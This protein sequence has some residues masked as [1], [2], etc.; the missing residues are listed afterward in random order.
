MKKLFKRLFTRTYTLTYL[1][2]N[3][4]YVQKFKTYEAAVNTALTL[5]YDDQYDPPDVSTN[6]AINGKP[7]DFVKWDEEPFKSYKRNPK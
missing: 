5:F 7:V 2:N 6:I 4:I 1:A 3:D